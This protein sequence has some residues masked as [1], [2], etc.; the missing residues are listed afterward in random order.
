MTQEL[1]KI[2]EVAEKLRCSKSQV[3][4]LMK[5]KEN[6]LPYIKLSPRLIYISTTDLYNFMASCV[7][8]K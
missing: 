2:D 1:L 5:R 6:P 7:I 8:S 4:K 3:Q